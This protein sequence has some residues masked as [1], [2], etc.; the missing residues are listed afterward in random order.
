MDNDSAPLK[1]AM[2][3]VGNFGG[4][5]RRLMRQTGLFRIVRAYDLNPKAL[6]HA[7]RDD[8]AEPAASYVDLLA[9][10]GIEAVVIS[11][12]AKFHAEQMLAAMARGL[13]VFVEKPLCAT[14]SEMDALMEAQ[15]RSGVV[16]GVGHDDSTRN[17]WLQ[18]IKAMI[19]AGELGTVATFE[20]TTAH[21]GGLQ[22]KHGD[23]R[24]DPEKNPGGMLFQCGVH[25]LHDLLYLFGPVAKVACAMRYNVHTTV[26]ADVAHCILTHASGLTGTLNAYHVTP[27]RHTFSIFGTQGALH[28][29][30]RYFDEGTTLVFQP[31]RGN[32]KEPEIPVTV[33]TSPDDQT[34]NLRSWYRAVRGGGPCYPSLTDGARAV[35][36]V[37]AAE[38][39]ARSG[40]VECV[41]EVG[42]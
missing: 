5:R 17:P 42:L 24:G 10:P 40:H 35:A 41:A 23:W 22:I 36:V 7:R 29:H 37:F 2:V 9:T 13:H 21:S 6:E 26:T 14:P 28:K 38:T 31:Y 27:Y 3:G 25:A 8:G 12:G 33:E 4:A 19:Q 15:R 18:R 16:V 30:D 1:V 32:E 11:T 39:A 34:G 20:K